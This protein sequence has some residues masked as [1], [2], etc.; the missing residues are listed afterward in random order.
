MADEDDP[1]NYHNKYIIQNDERKNNNIN[2]NSRR[3]KAKN[4]TT[5]V[6]SVDCLDAIIKNSPK[7]QTQ[8]THQK[9]ST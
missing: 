2:Y 9:Q 4:R 1:N 3:T 7:K 8:K 6:T 5:T